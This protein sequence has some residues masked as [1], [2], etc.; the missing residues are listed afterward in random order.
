MRLAFHELGTAE[1]QRCAQMR[2][3]RFDPASGAV[4]EF[5]SGYTNRELPNLWDRSEEVRSTS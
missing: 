3:R 1:N 4:S 5:V 2:R